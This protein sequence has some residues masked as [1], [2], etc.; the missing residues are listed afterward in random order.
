MRVANCVHTSSVF[1]IRPPSSSTPVDGLDRADACDDGEQSS[2]SA[3]W[4]S[5]SPSSRLPPSADDR[6]HQ[7]PLPTRLPTTPTTVLRLGFVRGA[8]EQRA[9]GVSHFL[10]HQV[11]N[12]RR[13]NS[14]CLG[15][16]A[17]LPQKR[18]LDSGREEQRARATGLRGSPFGGV[19]DKGQLDHHPQRAQ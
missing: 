2:S 3:P 8:S 4:P 11:P 15:M 17:S 16:T 19:S 6:D 9:D 5:S 1:V 13:Q 18:I 7:A 10:L 14:F 12:H